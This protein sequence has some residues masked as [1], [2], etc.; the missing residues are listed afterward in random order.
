MTD[1]LSRTCHVCGR[2]VASR[3]WYSTV[4]QEKQ[5]AAKGRKHKAP[6]RVYACPACFFERL[7]AKQ[8]QDYRREALA[9]AFTNAPG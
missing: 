9:G 3:V 7:D 4:R 8:R 2:Q 6:T 1:M 5:R